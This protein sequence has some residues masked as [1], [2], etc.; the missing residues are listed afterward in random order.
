MG[1]HRWPA[2]SC[3]EIPSCPVPH[4]WACSPSPTWGTLPS[5]PSRPD[6][7]GQ[8]NITGQNKSQQGK[9]P[10]KCTANEGLVRIHYKCL[11]SI[12]VFP[13][14]KLLFPT[15][16]YNVLSPSSYTH[17]S[18][19]DLYIFPGSVCQFCCREICGRILRI[20]KSL[21]DTWM[22]KLGPRPHNSQKRNTYM[23]FSLQ[24]GPIWRTA[25]LLTLDRVGS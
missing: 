9:T 11:V 5:P 16:N 7:T 15:Q 3:A 8:S 1:T 17:I 18:V 24:C 2:L 21:T 13:E 14:M 10:V 4:S 23:G 25:H 22:W 20:Y 19:R 12:Y 6:P